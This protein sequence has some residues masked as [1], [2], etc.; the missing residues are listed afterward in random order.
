MKRL[1]NPRNRPLATLTLLALAQLAAG[2]AM[3]QQGQRV[4]R[5]TFQSG[6]DL[7]QNIC[8]GCHMPD[9]RGASGAGAYPALA[10]N[11]HLSAALYPVGV[12]INGRKAMPSFGESLTDEQIAAVVNFV[13]TR[14]GNKYKDKVTPEMVKV[15]RTPR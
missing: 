6:E 1:L 13:R 12:V 3:A 10:A 2:A 8:Q 7:Y 14:F 15:L 4:Q 9:A 11:K 5:F